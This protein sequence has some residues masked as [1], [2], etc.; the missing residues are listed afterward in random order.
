MEAKRQFLGWIPGQDLHVEEP[1]AGGGEAWPA[2]ARPPEDEDSGK[3]DDTSYL[4]H[5][6][7]GP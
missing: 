1:G 2:A 4:T 3:V 5:W 7:R 6:G